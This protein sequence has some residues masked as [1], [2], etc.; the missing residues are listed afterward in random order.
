MIVLVGQKRSP[1]EMHFTPR[2][3]RTEVVQ[4][5]FA[6]PV[7]PTWNRAA[8]DY[9]LREFVQEWARDHALPPWVQTNR[10]NEPVGKSFVGHQ[11][12][13][14]HICIDDDFDHL[15]VK[16]FITDTAAL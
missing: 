7:R 4:N 14:N 5:I 9:L 16:L 3:F 15:E 11:G 8:V 6:F 2:G 13:N 10:K 1:K 12:C